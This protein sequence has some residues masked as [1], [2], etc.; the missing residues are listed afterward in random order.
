MKKNLA[1]GV[2]LTI[3][4]IIAI[5]LAL[6]GC[7]SPAS[8]AATSSDA[9]TPEVAST[10]APVGLDE[11]FAT[12]RTSVGVGALA[13]HPHEGDWGDGPLTEALLDEIA[14]SGFT[15]VRLPVRFS[16]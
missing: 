16:G 9:G 3:V 6:T 4:G 13:G 2:G 12:M 11:V 5:A 14:D 15:A 1:P 10:Q 8:P 7:T